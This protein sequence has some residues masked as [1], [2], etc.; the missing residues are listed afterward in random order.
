[1]RIPLV[2]KYT[3]SI[4]SDVFCFDSALSSD[5]FC[6]DSALSSDI[7][8]LNSA[9]S[10]DILYLIS[11]ENVLN[12]KSNLDSRALVCPV[13]PVWRLVWRLLIFV[14]VES[15]KRSSCNFVVAISD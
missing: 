7:F 13:K 5:I 3:S 6:F 11:L 1:M 15:L 10:S 8:Y 12:F 2:V 4:M 14:F 9:L